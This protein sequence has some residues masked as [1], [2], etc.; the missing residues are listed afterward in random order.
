MPLCGEMAGQQRA[1]V[2]LLGMG[3][4]NFSM[5]PAFLS[6]IKS[7]A[8]HVTVSDA[9]AILRTALRMKT[10]ARVQ[11]LVRDRLRDLAPELA[12]LDVQQ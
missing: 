4:R 5:S 2:L 8:K 3:L 9:E 1:F 12:M 11:R 7:L 10:T 6:P